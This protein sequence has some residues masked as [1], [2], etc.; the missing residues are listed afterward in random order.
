MAWSLL[1][2]RWLG[3]GVP[4]R[5]AG[6][7]ASARSGGVYGVPCQLPGWF[8]DY[9][10][11]K[12]PDC[13]GRSASDVGPALVS[14]LPVRCWRCD[15]LALTGWRR[16]SSRLIFASTRPFAA[17]RLGQSILCGSGAVSGRAV[18]SATA[19]GSAC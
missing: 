6:D 4:G 9:V 2:S 3:G 19:W 12:F 11:G 1:T 13:D 5:V 15:V 16:E 8:A 10:T 17:A 18:W 7:S 14:S